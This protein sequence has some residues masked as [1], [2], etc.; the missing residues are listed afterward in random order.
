MAYN[1]VATHT[2]GILCVIP[3]PSLEYVL[4]TTVILSEYALKTV[5]I[6]SAG[7]YRYVENGWV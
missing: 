6:L 3:P 5:V 7:M 4:K 2:I 1:K